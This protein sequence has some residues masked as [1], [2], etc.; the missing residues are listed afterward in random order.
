MA[1][2]LA[3]LQ[4]KADT[5]DLERAERI[6]KRL[7]ATGKRAA[8]DVDYLGD[9]LKDTAREAK[10]A[11]QQFSKTGKGLGVLKKAAL[12]AAAGFS[13]ISAT[14]KLIEV[15]REF[16]V[17]NASLKTMTGSAEAAE[18]AFAQIQ[19]F[20]ATTPFD[21]AQVAQAF[22]KLKALG[23]D[24]SEEALLS[25]G[26]TASAMGKS[27]DQMV[28]AVAD[29]ATGEF[30]RLKEFGIKSR[31]EGDRV[32]FTFRGVT[33]TVRKSSEEIQGYLLG[34]GQ[35]DFAGAM[36][37]RSE[38]LDGALSNLAD[39]W[40][41]LFLTIAN[42]GVADLIEDTSRSTIRLLDATSQL[43]K[44]ISGEQLTAQEQ[45]NRARA[46][47]SR[48]LDTQAQRQKTY[49]GQLSVRERE[50]LSAN[51]AL[52]KSLE[53]Q[54]ALEAELAERQGAPESGAD[55]A[56]GASDETRKIEKAKTA[57]YLAEIM[58]LRESATDRVNRIEK[59]QLDKLA[60]MKKSAN[61]VGLQLDSEFEA[62]RTE[63]V[64]AAEEERKAI[65][66]EARAGER[67]AKIAELEEEAKRLEEF[68]ALQD[69]RDKEREAQKA[70]EEAERLEARK[71]KI[72]EHTNA[73]SA[74]EDVFMKGKS[75]KEKAAFAL[76][77]GLLNA[78]KRERAKEIV[79]KS[80]NAAMGAYES[81]AP[82]P[83]VGPALGA[84]AAAAIL[85]QGV[86]FAAK[87]LAGRALGGQVRPGESYVVGERGP[88][89]LTMGNS[90][91]AITPNEAMGGAQPVVNKTANV[92]FNIQANDTAGFDQLL[93]NRRGL[94]IN[95]INEALNDQGKAAIA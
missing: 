13:A 20:A 56:T 59:E 74:I 58:T 26:N 88:E 33:T 86:Q 6:L 18:E 87:S 28:E 9:E 76:S 25:Y 80:Y 52:I 68:N 90:R 44:L 12:G 64:K 16:D 45:L 41:N 40:D 35:T 89:I 84:A 51:Q 81:L 36:A 55:P 31:S 22:V 71:Q 94:I 10:K 73:I 5:S 61:E 14:T 95:V 91:G 2:E 65:R 54:L 46:E 29:A 48:L 66:D 15:A 39:S 85:A 43:V 8:N 92:S 3:T 70:E 42:A 62:A 82:I 4:F 53:T 83:V 50:Q 72:Q 69:E 49:G 57:E 27:L 32:S 47:E 21:L 1:T 24:P 37:E 7:G 30:E 77:A 79:S 60:E 63:I 67:D 93:L 38:T 34:L 19:E 75:E 23:L 78:E 17:I 11:D